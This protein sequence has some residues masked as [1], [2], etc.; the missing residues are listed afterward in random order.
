MVS[1]QAIEVRTKLLE[2]CCIQRPWL[3]A[4]YYYSLYSDIVKKSFIACTAGLVLS[5]SESRLCSASAASLVR[6]SPCSKP[7]LYVVHSATMHTYI[8]L[9]YALVRVQRSTKP[10][11][12]RCTH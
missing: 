3:S 7:H 4:F 5:C 8:A 2:Y 11:S 1:L 6:A 10:T 12:S 9:L